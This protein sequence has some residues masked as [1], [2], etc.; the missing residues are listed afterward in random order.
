MADIGYLSA[1]QLT[2]LL[3]GWVVVL[4]AMLKWSTA[5]KK[6]IRFWIVIHGQYYLN[7]SAAF[8]LISIILGIMS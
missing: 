1:M 6:H 4:Y 3:S 2:F 8:F 7:M 5:E